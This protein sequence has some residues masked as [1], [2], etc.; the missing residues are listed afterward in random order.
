MTEMKEI[1][2]AALAV[3]GAKAKKKLAEDKL[4]KKREEFESF[5]AQSSGID[6][7]Q[8]KLKE[9][10]RYLTK[11][12]AELKETEPKL[13]ND[14]KRLDAGFKT[15]VEDSSSTKASIQLAW[16]DLQESVSEYKDTVGLI[17][18]N[19]KEAKKA[20]KQII[21]DYPMDAEEVRE[22][23]NVG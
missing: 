8:T 16:Q 4:K 9:W 12:K 13:K 11:S 10:S 19:I 22:A 3:D 14:L 2:I 1:K 6:E 18:G 5:V 15:T 20:I 23:M 7:P 21:D 17:R